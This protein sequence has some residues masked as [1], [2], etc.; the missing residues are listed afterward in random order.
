MRQGP[1]EKEESLERLRTVLRGLD[2]L[3]IAYS[4]G[5]DSTFLLVMAH[6]VLGDRVLGVLDL[7]L[8]HP[9]H[10]TEEAMA[11]ARGL[12]IPFLSLPAE[13]LSAHGIN[14]DDL[15]DYRP[16]LEAAKEAGM[17]APLVEAGLGKREIRM[18]S[19]R[20]GLPTWNKPSEACLATRIP[21][22]V[23]LRP[24]LLGR[25]EAAEAFL[26]GKGFRQLRVRLHGEVARIEVLK[27]EIPRLLDPSLRLEIAR[28][29]RD[30]G[31]LHVA[32]D[33]EGYASGR[34]NRGLEGLSA[35]R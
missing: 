7:S 4:G 30:L 31:C 25:V 13:G 22:G 19:E 10:E 5:V 34:M 26:R 17:L 35:K 6:Q 9:R 21:Y 28:R 20:M 3:V 12:G 8:L 18:L 29:L 11:L 14:V 15:G 2:G 1:G 24:E 16:G 23:P 27:E 33:L 32:V